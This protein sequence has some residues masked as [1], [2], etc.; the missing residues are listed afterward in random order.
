[1]NLHKVF[2]IIFH[3]WGILRWKCHI[4]I[5]NRC[6]HSWTWKQSFFCLHLCV[7][8][9]N[10]SIQVSEWVSEWVSV[11]IESELPPNSGDFDPILE[12]SMETE[13]SSEY[14]QKCCLVT[15]SAQRG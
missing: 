13:F 12:T 11:T 10:G 3:E 1:M 15:S 2:N 6:Y 7:D 8:E 5:L 4:E 9:A 14:L